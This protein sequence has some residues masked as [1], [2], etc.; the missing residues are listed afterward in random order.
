MNALRKTALAAAAVLALSF[1]STTNA[2]TSYEFDQVHSQI[3]FAVS[4]LVVSKT[5]GEFKQYT[6]T[7]AFDKED[8]AGSSV[9]V[10]IQADSIDTENEKRDNHLKSPDFFNVAEFPEITFKGKEIKENAGGY[11]IIGDLTLK[12][13]TKE[14]TIPVEIN[15]PVV[16]PNNGKKVIG[17]SGQTTI[18][19]QDFGVSW[20]KTMDNGGLVVG[21]E[22]T[23]M[24]EI[25]AHS[26]S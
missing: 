2:A 7:I 3:G 15:G 19:R 4:H 17:I 25:E 24:I 22:V 18:N 14:I 1:P 23:V 16:H 21:D 13:V 8:L 10:T 5:K 26:Q 11:E 9:D 12:G 6:G 20:N